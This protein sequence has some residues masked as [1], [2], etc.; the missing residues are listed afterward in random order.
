MKKQIRE[1]IF[2]KYSGKCAYCGTG[3]EKGWHVDHI[4]PV[5]RDS[6]WSRY[7]GR[8]VPTGKLQ[9]PENEHIDNYNPSCASCN[10]Q[11]NS[12]TLEEFRKNIKNFVNSLNNYSTQYKFAKRYGLITE[13]KEDVIFYFEKLNNEQKNLG[14]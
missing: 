7:H 5:V 6:K 11:K 3:L 8:F 9:N 2:N 1:Q 10:I 14:S 12:F 13:T 4:E